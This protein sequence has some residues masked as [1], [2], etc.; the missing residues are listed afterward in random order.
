MTIIAA[1]PR[2]MLERKPRHGDPCNRCGLCCYAS[3]CDVAHA[4]Y[5]TR[6]GPCPELQWDADGS[7]C[8]LIDRS[9]G[10]AREDAKL[11]INSG[12]GCDMILRGEPRN[13]RYTAQ[14]ADIDTKN[15]ER[16]DAARTRFGLIK[17][18]ERQ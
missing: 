2:A 3:L 8:G 1:V 13:Y 9:T 16:L 12:N 15:R 4:I 11:L 7:R 17:P 10:E 14:L 6:T 5:G 18:K